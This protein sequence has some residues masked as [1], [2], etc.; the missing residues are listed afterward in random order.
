MFTSGPSLYAT[1]LQDVELNLH[2]ADD[3]LK[4]TESFENRATC[5]NPKRIA[6]LATSALVGIGALAT[7][8]KLMSLNK[9]L[10]N[11]DVSID[12][13]VP[14]D[15]PKD[16]KIVITTLEDQQALT[17]N[18]NDTT[19]PE[20]KLLNCTKTF[21]NISSTEHLVDLT[22]IDTG[23]TNMTELG[24][25]ITREAEDYIDNICT[26]FTS[27]LMLADLKTCDKDGFKA[28]LSNI[29][30]PQCENPEDVGGNYGGY[31]GYG[32]YGGYGGNY[33][34]YGGYGGNYGGYGGDLN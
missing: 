9:P 3:L 18:S 24:E 8:A 14:T 32:G 1:E 22:E 17:T 7:G 26:N 13:A 15:A 11:S 31:S 23:D 21:L 28:C 12:K 19:Q 34:G 29:S 4:Y 20:P 10:E 33:G 6:L 16:P 5:L 2:D 27:L 25:E 30:N